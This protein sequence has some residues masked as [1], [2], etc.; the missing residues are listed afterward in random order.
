MFKAA[1]TVGYL[2]CNILRRRTTVELDKLVVPLDQLPFKA[3][4]GLRAQD[5]LQYAQARRHNQH[6][7][8]D[9]RDHPARRGLLHFANPS[10]QH[11]TSS[12][13]V[14]MALMTVGVVTLVPTSRMY[15]LTVNTYSRTNRSHSTSFQE[16]RMNSWPASVE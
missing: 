10:S 5:C 12:T 2:G 15:R 1:R 3:V 7:E 8:G 14:K 11:T 6:V 13:H 9:S 16:N 4:D